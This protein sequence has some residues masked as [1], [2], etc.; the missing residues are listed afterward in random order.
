MPKQPALSLAGA[1]LEALEDGK[2]PGFNS[3]VLASVRRRL[4]A[5]PRSYLPTADPIPRL[6]DACRLFTDGGF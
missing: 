3:P 2:L 5:G 4:L 1:A 6:P